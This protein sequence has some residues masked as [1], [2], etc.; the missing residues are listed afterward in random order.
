MQRWMFPPNIGP[1]PTV[2]GIFVEGAKGANFG[3]C[4]TQP[5]LVKENFRY[6]TIHIKRPPARPLELV[7]AAKPNYS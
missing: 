5:F 3:E 6:R 1:L 4:A 7:A 2:K